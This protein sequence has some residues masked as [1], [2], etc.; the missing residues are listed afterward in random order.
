MRVD[1]HQD[2]RSKSGMGLESTLPMKS[3][4]IRHDPF[5]ELSATDDNRLDAHT[6]VS[7]YRPSR[8]DDEGE[9]LS[10]AAHSLTHAHNPAR[11]TRRSKRAS[12]PPGSWRSAGIRGGARRG[13]SSRRRG[14]RRPG[15]RGRCGR[16][17]AGRC[18]RGR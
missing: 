17:L 11:P 18:G 3:R 2:V 1:S 4:K 12:R 5:F 14:K 9:S 8:G 15:C 13:R 6:L 16:V 7:R 10:V